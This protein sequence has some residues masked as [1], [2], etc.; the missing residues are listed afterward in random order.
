MERKLKESAKLD[1]KEEMLPY[2]NSLGISLRSVSF[3]VY[4]ISTAEVI[5][6]HICLFRT[7]A[8]SIYIPAIPDIENEFQVSL[9]VALLP[10]SFYV[11]GQAWGPLLGAPLSETFGRRG[12]YIPYMLLFA[13]GAGFSHSIA[14]LIVCR[15]FAGLFGSP[16]LSVGAGTI[17][18]IWSQ[19]DRGIPM[20][21]LVLVPFLGPS[22]G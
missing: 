8:S 6:A 7:I 22:L 20:A 12:T 13:L 19:Q 15:F 14:S 18:D 17:A 21:I 1:P 4:S 11:F 10:Y 9:T 2:S 16:V 3:A 5:K